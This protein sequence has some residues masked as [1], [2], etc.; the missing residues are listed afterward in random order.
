MEEDYKLGYE[1]G[2]YEVLEALKI[3]LGNQKE[4]LFQKILSDGKVDQTM[5]TQLD[6]IDVLSNWVI[7]EMEETE[8]D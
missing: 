6:L 8:S 4:P 2:R 1:N 3:K 5:S 7:D